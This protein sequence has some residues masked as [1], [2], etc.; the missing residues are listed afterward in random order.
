M[1]ERHTKQK[2]IIM[3]FLEQNKNKHLSI[4]DIQEGIGRTASMVTIYRMIHK[5]VSENLIIKKPLENK[6]GFC[7]QF[8][9]ACPK[10]NHVHNHYHMICSKCD[11]V[12]HYDNPKITEI[13]TLIGNDIGFSVD[14]E[15]L[16]FYGICKECLAH[17]I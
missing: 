2:E 5:L 14:A 7:Y 15:K 11:K 9:E 12:F 4:E 17:N 1:A 13:C 6:Q 16:A 10:C 8:N 3:G